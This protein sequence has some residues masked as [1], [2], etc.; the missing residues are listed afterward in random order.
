M[1]AIRMLVAIATLGVISVP[2]VGVGRT[3]SYLKTSMRIIK[4]SADDN[5]SVAFQ[6]ER[7]KQMLD[8]LQPE[9][10]RSRITLAEAEV[11][12]SR[13]Q[14]EVG[15]LAQQLDSD[16]ERML[17][18]RQMLVSC[19]DE[20]YLGG[21][22]LT[23]R[24]IEQQLEKRLDRFNRAESIMDSKKRLME[25]RRT[26]AEAARSK[27]SR[28]EQ[29]RESLRAQIA[30][31]ESRMHV[32]DSK[33]S[34]VVLSLNDGLIEEAKALSS[35]LDRRLAVAEKVIEDEDVFVDAFEGPM[36]RDVVAEIDRKF[37]KGKRLASRDR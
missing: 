31:F 21:R 22:R 19:D 18:Q 9:F 20:L 32:L 28:H 24:E 4:S 8:D 27:M 3:M 13:L 2:V 29:Q 36:D 26:A 1:R 7:L 23:R 34:P 14:E 11:D 25:A 17:E 15:E 5:T 35:H 6:L 12:A 10:E 30:E 37:R 16:R 33:S